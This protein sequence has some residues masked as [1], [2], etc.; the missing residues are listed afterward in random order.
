VSQRSPRSLLSRARP[1]S[2]PKLDQKS[3]PPGRRSSRLGGMQRPHR[4]RPQE[5]CQHS[6]LAFHSRTWRLSCRSQTRVPPN[7]PAH[8]RKCLRQTCPHGTCSWTVCNQGLGT[9][10]AP[11]WARLSVA[12]WARQWVCSTESTWAC[13]R[14]WEL[15]RESA[16]RWVR[17]S[18]S[19]RA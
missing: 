16:V 5:E 4:S 2:C 18:E 1:S 14:A 15:G 17:S 6:W 8:C 11:T 12:G 10:T 7:R 3:R 19:G 9:A 13:W